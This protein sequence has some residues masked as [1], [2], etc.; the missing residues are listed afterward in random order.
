[1]RLSGAIFI[2]I[3]FST[4][5]MF[6]YANL[7]G[8]YKFHSIDKNYCSFVRETTGNSPPG[9]PYFLVHRDNYWNLM[10]HDCFQRGESDG[11]G[12]FVRLKSE[13]LI[14][15]HYSVTC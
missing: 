13:G 4:E 14:Q 9:H 12:V 5:L 10:D 8:K 15:V 11:K 1:M 2:Q 7:S 3:T 6:S